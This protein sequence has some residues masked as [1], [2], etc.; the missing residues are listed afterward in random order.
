VRAERACT[1]RNENPEEA[2]GLQKER[3]PHDKA[4]IGASPEQNTG[5]PADSLG[6]VNA[7]PE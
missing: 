6:V 5:I 7:P 3:R 1:G 4:A 2:R